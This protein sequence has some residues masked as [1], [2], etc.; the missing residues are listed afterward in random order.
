MSPVLRLVLPTIL[1]VGMAVLGIHVMTGHDV[2]VGERVMDSFRDVGRY[3]VFLSRDNVPV[4]LVYGLVFMGVA[5]VTIRDWIRLV[6]LRGN[7][8]R[9]EDD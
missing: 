8:N 9:R 5:V 3:P 2:V 1:T 7:Q 4:M 6:N